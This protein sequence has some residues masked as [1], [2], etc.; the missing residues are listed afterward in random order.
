M[1]SDSLI[2]LPVL[3]VSR[4]ALS[5][6]SLG[7]MIFSARAQDASGAREPTGE[8]RAFVSR[9]T[10]ATFSSRASF[11]YDINK[12][13][14]TIPFKTGISPVVLVKLPDFKNAVQGIEDLRIV[15]D[16]IQRKWGGEHD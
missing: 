15:A 8:L 7:L 9:G 16:T 13:T 3:K 12:K 14:P 5:V 4:T 2:Q 10:T 6:L 11:S 1:P